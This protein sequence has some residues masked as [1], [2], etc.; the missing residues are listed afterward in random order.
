MLLVF[1][2]V[3]LVVQV[4]LVAQADLDKLPVL[5]LAQ[6]NVQVDQLDSALVPQDIQVPLVAQEVPQLVQEEPQLKS[7][8]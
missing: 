6:V 2:L 8:Q 4:A 3:G 7:F 5:R 1:H